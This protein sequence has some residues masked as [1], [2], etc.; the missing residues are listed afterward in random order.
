[1]SSKFSFWY[2]KSLLQIV[3]FR[4]TLHIWAFH[5]ANKCTQR[6][7]MSVLLLTNI[8]LKS[9]RRVEKYVKVN[10]R[11]VGIYKNIK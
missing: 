6:A 7:G 3:Y 1:M 8:R 2:S 5:I 10:I 11:N 9:I 4:Y